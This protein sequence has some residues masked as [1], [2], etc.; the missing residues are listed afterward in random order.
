MEETTKNRP[1]ILVS[2]DDGIKASG[3][4]ALVNVLRQFGDVVV[5]APN[6]S[7]SGMSH[8]ITVQTPLY[9]T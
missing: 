9:A 1:L 8:A 7:Y 2:N 5:A 6:Q 4:V 3:L